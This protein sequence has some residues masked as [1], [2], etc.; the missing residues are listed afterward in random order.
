MSNINLADLLSSVQSSE[1]EFQKKLNSLSAAIKI[2]NIDPLIYN[3][4]SISDIKE[5][6]FTATSALHELEIE[7]D[8]QFE[9]YKEHYLSKKPSCANRHLAKES[10]E[11]R[12]AILGISYYNAENT[13][14]SAKSQYNNHYQNDN[15]IPLYLRIPKN[16]SISFYKKLENG[17]GPNFGYTTELNLNNEEIY[18]ELNDAVLDSRDH[19]K[20]AI[21]EKKFCMDC[22][23]WEMHGIA[24]KV[25][26]FNP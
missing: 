2:N 15:N 19:L 9:L 22:F 13:F 1:R 10:T 14:I 16:K 5:K 25:L 7:I 17:W 18:I 11:E 24:H 3:N 8:K 21:L 6:Y 23:Y 26:K 12:R 4:Q 20:H